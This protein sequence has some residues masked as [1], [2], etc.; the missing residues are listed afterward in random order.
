MQSIVQGNREGCYI[1][2]RQPTEEHHIFGGVADRPL[3]EQ[4]GLKVNLCSFHHRDSKSGVHFNPTLAELIKGKGKEAFVQH[5]PNKN[6]D[7]IFI[8]GIL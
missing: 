7:D 8:K 5:Y 4:Y 6:F 3:S 2:G 1:C